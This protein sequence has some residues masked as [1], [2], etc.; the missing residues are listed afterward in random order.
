[1]I[2]NITYSNLISFLDELSIP[3]KCVIFV[4]RIADYTV[5]HYVVVQKF[6]S[7]AVVWTADR[8]HLLVGECLHRGFFWLQY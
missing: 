6:H 3:I 1:M 4:Q 7:L 2:S 5:L 8:A